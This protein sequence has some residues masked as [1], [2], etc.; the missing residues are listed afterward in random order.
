MKKHIGYLCIAVFVGVLNFFIHIDW[1]FLL[2]GCIL[3]GFITS[4]AHVF[5]KSTRF[6]DY[7]EQFSQVNYGEIKAFIIMQSIQSSLLIS[8]FVFALKYIR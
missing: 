1:Y 8:A 4:I 6:T 2:I 5:F 3:C 7:L